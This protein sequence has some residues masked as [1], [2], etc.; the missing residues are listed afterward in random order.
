V[1]LAELSCK[2]GNDFHT[3]HLCRG[4][5]NIASCSASRSL[6][7]NLVGTNDSTLAILYVTAGWA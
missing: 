3:G 2:A 1:S 7:L 4:L 6:K 5:F